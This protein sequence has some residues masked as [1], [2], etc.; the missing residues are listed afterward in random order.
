MGVS[1]QVDPQVGL[2]RYW[3]RVSSN[4]YRYGLMSALVKA[5]YDS[6]PLRGRYSI[7]LPEDRLL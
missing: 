7:A 5:H 2:G 6:V 4:I 3:L 1:R